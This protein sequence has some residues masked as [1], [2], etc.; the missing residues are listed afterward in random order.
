[1]DQKLASQIGHVARA[2]RLARRLTQED[3]AEEIGVST[4]FYARL[5]RGVALPSVET[6][7]RLAPSLRVSADRLLGLANPADLATAA[8]VEPA[9]SADFRR[10][11]RKLRDAP[12]RLLK[13]LITV[14]DES[15]RQR[16]TR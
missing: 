7:V 4:E 2:A 3:L 11:A 13:A 12:P 15:A 10:L 16:R 6:L 14:A 8:V 5:E 1:M 9:A